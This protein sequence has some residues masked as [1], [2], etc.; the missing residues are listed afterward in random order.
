MHVRLHYL[1]A[2]YL[3]AMGKSVSVGILYVIILFS[4]DHN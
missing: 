1:N 2:D 3:C 4:T